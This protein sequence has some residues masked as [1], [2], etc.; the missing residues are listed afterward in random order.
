[1]SITFVTL[2]IKQLK[3]AVIIDSVAK[4]WGPQECEVVPDLCRCVKMCLA[5]GGRVLL[6]SPNLC[7]DTIHLHIRVH[8][9]PNKILLLFRFWDLVPAVRYDLLMA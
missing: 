2:L 1:M 8:H 6:L 3:I 4:L 9:I 7:C 5:E